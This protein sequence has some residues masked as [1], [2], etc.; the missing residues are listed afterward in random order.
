MA[1]TPDRYTAIGAAT[2]ALVALRGHPFVTALAIAVGVE[3]AI[4][5]TARYKPGLLGPAAGGPLAKS[6]I[7]VAG[8]MAGWAA[9]RALLPTACARLPAR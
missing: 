9:T 2:G 5:V 4:Q 3:A 1:V 6:A 8:M 7:D